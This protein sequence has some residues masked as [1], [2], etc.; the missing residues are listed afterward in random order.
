MKIIVWCGFILVISLFLLVSCNFNIENSIKYGILSDIHGDVD[1]LNHFLNRFQEEKVDAI[2]ILGDSVFN[3][4]LYGL[5]DKKD[6]AL[7]MNEVLDSVLKKFPNLPIY[8][9]PGNHETKRS[10]DEVLEGYKQN[11]IYANLIDM[12]SQRFVDGD[13]VDIISLPGYYLKA[14]YMEEDGYFISDEM[15][16]NVSK[17]VAMAD[18]PVLLISHGPPKGIN[19]DSIDYADLGQRNFQQAVSYANYGENVGSEK[20]LEVM[21]SNNIKFGLFGHIHEAYGATDILGNVVQQGVFS[22]ELLFNP[23][24]VEDGRAGI[25]EIID[26]KIAFDIINS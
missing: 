19:K 23:G 3:E 11:P 1:S 13:V 10:Y 2:L 14:S 6:D 5:D 24:S 9:I 7:E 16:Q 8:I 15:M 26:G 20:M 21:K 25:V 22:K 17:F 4:H 12:N 18:S